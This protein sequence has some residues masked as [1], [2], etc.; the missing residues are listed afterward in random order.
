MD[1]HPPA[2]EGLSCR[3]DRPEPHM[4]PGL[5]R[6]QAWAW[7]L[8][9]FPALSRP[10]CQ[11]PEL[12][13][14]WD[15]GACAMLRLA[16]PW[17]GDAPPAE[18]GQKRCRDPDAQADTAM[19]L[20]SRQREA[21]ATDRAATWTLKRPG[22]ARAGGGG[23]THGHVAPKSPGGP[24]KLLKTLAQVK[25]EPGEEKNS[26]IAW[27]HSAASTHAMEGAANPVRGP[28]SVCVDASLLDW[29]QRDKP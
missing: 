28:H 8:D 10:S 23:Q 4:P 29:P 13:G 1:P 26:S 15:P 3:W 27:A 12:C 19:E 17:H 6:E 22:D 9:N 18:R 21:L 7:A 14:V 5:N 24:R 11:R 2:L 16:C 20:Q 25:V